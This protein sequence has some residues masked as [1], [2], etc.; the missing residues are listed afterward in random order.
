[1]IS[2]WIKVFVLLGAK[3]H[4]TAGVIRVIEKSGKSYILKEEREIALK[5]DIQVYVDHANEVNIYLHFLIKI[6]LFCLSLHDSHSG[7]S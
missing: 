3:I 1:M 2:D 4:K 7:C 6:F 5:E